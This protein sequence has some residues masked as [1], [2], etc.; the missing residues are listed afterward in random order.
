MWC[1]VRL[2]SGLALDHVASEFRQQRA[3][4]AKLP[5]PVHS[6]HHVA[7]SGG[8]CFLDA[9]RGDEA[10]LPLS[11]ILP[12]RLAQLGRGAGATDSQIE[13]TG[14]GQRSL[15]SGSEKRESLCTVTSPA[16]CT[17]R[18]WSGSYRGLPTT[19][20]FMLCGALSG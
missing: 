17:S 16:S 8:S 15:N 4:Y 14:T 19:P 7:M 1:S 3:I 9:E 6:T 18:S 13:G 20:M 10:G 11:G 12:R 5:E 2:R